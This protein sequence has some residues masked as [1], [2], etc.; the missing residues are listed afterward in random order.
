MARSLESRIERLEQRQQQGARAPVFSG[1]VVVREGATPQDTR[2]RIEEARCAAAF[3][4]SAHIIARVI[5]APKG[6]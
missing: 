3:A 6:M 5:V 2:Q 4:P 1:R